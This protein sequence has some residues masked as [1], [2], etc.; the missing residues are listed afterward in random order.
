LCEGNCAKNVMHG[1]LVNFIMK[2]FSRGFLF[3]GCQTH[4]QRLVI[5]LFSFVSGGTALPTDL[6]VDPPLEVKKFSGLKTRKLWEFG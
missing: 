5:I 6:E 1:K 4:K 3:F 2:Y